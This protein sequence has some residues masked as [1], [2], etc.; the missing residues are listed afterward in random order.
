SNTIWAGE[1]ITSSTQGFFN[2]S[3]AGVGWHEVIA[4]YHQACDDNDTIWVEVE[5][6]S[7]QFVS[8]G[9]V[10]V[11]SDTLTLSVQATEGVWSG[12]GVVDSLVGVVDPGLLLPGS[13]YFTYT[14]LN[15]CAT[16][17]SVVLM[18]QDFP[19]IQIILQD[20][21]CVDQSPVVVTAN[22]GGG[23]FSGSGIAQQNA[24][25]QFSPSDAGVGDAVIQYDYSGV[26]TVSVL[27]SI[28]VFPLPVP[29]VSSDTTICPEGEALLSVSGVVNCQW[30][31]A[32]SLQ[33]PQQTMSVAE[34]DVTTT[35]TVLGESENGCFASAE[36]TVNVY[37]SPIVTT[38]APL[39]LCYGE[40]DVLSVSGLSEAVWSGPAIESPNELSTLVSPLET[41]IYTV[42][43][44]DQHGC[45]GETTAEVIIYNPVALFTSSDT[46]GVPPLEVELTNLS[47]GDYFVWDLGN[48]D[49][50][51]TTDVSELVSAVYQGE[52]GHPITLTAY[53]NGCP[54]EFSLNIVT[55]YDS[56]LLI[57]P[58]V[59]TPNG[60]GKNDYWWVKTQNMDQMHIDIFN[61]WGNLV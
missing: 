19:A 51:I 44:T 4:A 36:V 10:C 50:I 2:P 54:E 6:G 57:I 7:I 53:L 52:Q 55:Y 27:D 20:G 17:D 61:R 29:I 16:A 11:D 25:W 40:S 21:I 12:L 47:V 14:L 42:S 43:G 28:E 60:D 58:N 37:D 41:S 30:S 18:I 59:V 24:Q 45:I 8:P 5:D 26:C 3:V 1:G 48:G 39:E 49:T 32:S 13:H 56:E 22:P 31:P 9:S 34:P 15:S 38:N 33:T 23:V 35:Y 46:L